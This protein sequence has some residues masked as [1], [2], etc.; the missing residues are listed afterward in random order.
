MEEN[1]STLNG[2]YERKKQLTVRA[3]INGV[4]YDL[5]GSLHHGRWINETLPIATIV[6]PSHPTIEGVISESDIARVSI[7]T[8]A[9]FIPDNPELNTVWAYVNEIEL[10]NLRFFDIPILA[11]IYGGKVPVQLD[12]SNQMVSDK[13]V[14]RVRFNISPVENIEVEHITRGVVHIQGE[15]ESFIKRAYNVVF[16]VLVRESGF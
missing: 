15:A 2:L 4:I 6:E 14:Y 13:S 11:S 9:K 3:P 7:K 1:R 8:S 12:G 10:A 5:E 16:S